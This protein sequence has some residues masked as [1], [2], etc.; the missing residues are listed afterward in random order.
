MDNSKNKELDKNFFESTKLDDKHAYTTCP[1][2]GRGITEAT[3]GLNGL[4][5]YCARKEK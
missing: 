3:D 2:C 5:I 1:E 4:C